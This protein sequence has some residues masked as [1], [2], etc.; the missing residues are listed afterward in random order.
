M[1]GFLGIASRETIN[2]NNLFLEN[3]RIECR[4]PD[5]TKHILDSNDE[6]NLEIIFN[7]LSILELTNYGSQPL[8]DDS[9]NYLMVFNGEI[10][11]YIELKK[12]LEKKGIKFKSKNSDSEVLFQGLI[13]EGKSFISK[14]IGQFSTVFID[15]EKKEILLFRDRTGQKPLFYTYDE[16]NLF[17]GSN[18]ISVSNTADLKEIDNPRV[19]EF[20]NIGVI[21]SPNTIFKNIYKVKPGEIIKFNFRNSIK[22]ENYFYW[23]STDYISENFE[24]NNYE[25]DK[26]ISDCIEIRMR[27]D[28]PVAAFCSG[29]LD[30]TLIIKKLFDLGINVPTFSVVNKNP[31]YDESKY[32]NQVIKKYKNEYTLKEI[33]TVVNFVDILEN[34]YNFD[35]PYMD[36]S[37]QPSSFILKEI[38]NKFKVAISGDGGDE[39]FFGYD[40]FQKEFRLLKLNK[41]FINLLYFFYPGWIGTGNKIL[42]YS[43]DYKESYSSYFEDRKFLKLLGFKRNSF[44][45]EKY[46]NNCQNKL[47]N[48][49][50]LENS[51]YLSEMMNLK[52]DRTSMM[53]SVEVRSPFVDHR[54][55]EYILSCKT[56]TINYKFPKKYVKEILVEDFD[57]EF[58]ERPK[59][60]FVF[61][62]EKIIYENKE[63]IIEIIIN[64]QL[65]EHVPKLNLNILFLRKSRINSQRIFKL[66]ILALFIENN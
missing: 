62:L 31:Q 43:S 54:L 33:D 6:L 47:K 14:L 46:L 1:C 8:T 11:N 60:G 35:E 30:S 3:K 7:R 48:L 45:K 44:I 34:I 18:L 16:H 23:K 37:N 55:I 52:I 64:S 63:K 57:K 32:I 42:R 36:A 2:K 19:K 49:L 15:K 65:K 39:I 5:E 4:G 25:F 26:L 20:L 29:G 59:M 13:H 22:K 27:S 50:I 58:L 40:R 9:K 28:V 41:Y 66:L 21:T 61:D 53:H 24:F 38:S 51:F 10:F 12:Y 17:F 56:N